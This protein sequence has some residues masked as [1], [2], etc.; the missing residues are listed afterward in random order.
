M[1]CF[2]LYIALL[3]LFIGCKQNGQSIHNN[4]SSIVQTNSVIANDNKEG[5]KFLMEFYTKYY[6]EYR[7]TKG[8]ENF[9]SS[10]ILSRMDSLS[11]D[12]NLV[13]DYNPFIKAQDYD[14]KT[15]M[16][17]LQ[18]KPL[19][20][21]NEFRVS[22]L[23]FNGEG[24]DRTNVDLLLEKNKDGNF[25]ISSILNDEYLNFKNETSK[26]QIATPQKLS[27]SAKAKNLE[28]SIAGKKIILKN[29]IINEMSLSTSFAPIRDKEFYVMYEN[30]ASMVKTAEIY[31][32]F[33]DNN[34]LKLSSKEVLKFGP[35]GISDN[36]FLYD[37]KLI[38][39]S[40]D[41]EKLNNLESTTEDSFTKDPIK[42]NVFKN[43]KKIESKEY[44]NISPED[45]F[46]D[47]STFK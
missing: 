43:S 5:I 13:L 3:L 39:T 11:T 23:L 45:Y 32:L 20:N 24:E 29:T 36:L 10:R 28:I 18:I 26:K 15:L 47:K 46:V 9:V 16:K 37:N 35:E 7:D 25:L 22:F 12:G 44:K 34:T 17:T 1:K 6:G 38:D 42:K 21:L 19:K 40:Y 2:N 27:L 31:K 30:N 8:I 14:N 33:Y 4:E 41:Y